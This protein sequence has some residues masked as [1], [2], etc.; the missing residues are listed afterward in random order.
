LSRLT[1]RGLPPDQLLR[2]KTAWTVRLLAP[3]IG[4]FS[5]SLFRVTR[6]VSTSLQVSPDRG[7]LWSGAV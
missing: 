1:T 4:Q 3:R 5:K 7:L 6:G 2:F